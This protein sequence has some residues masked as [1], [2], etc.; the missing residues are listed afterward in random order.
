MLS[1]SAYTGTITRRHRIPKPPPNEDIFYTLDDFNIGNEITVYS[2]TFK[3]VN[4]DD[5]T[6][7]FMTKLGIRLNQ[8]IQIPDDPYMENRK[9]VCIQLHS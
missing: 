2:R 9:A 8:P 1:Y 6:R 7:N 5:F 4:V 3:L